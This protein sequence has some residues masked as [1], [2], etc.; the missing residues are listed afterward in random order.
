MYALPLIVAH[1]EWQ[2]N[3]LGTFF[4]VEDGLAVTATRVDG[5]KLDG[6][7]D[8]NTEVGRAGL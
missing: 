6:V 2:V 8:R 3:E 7:G 5:N 4:A 1:H